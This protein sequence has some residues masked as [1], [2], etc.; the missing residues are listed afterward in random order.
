MHPDISVQVVT[1][2]IEALCKVHSI[3]KSD[4]LLAAPSNCRSLFALDRAIDWHCVIEFMEWADVNYSVDWKKVGAEF[5]ISSKMPRVKKMLQHCATMKF[6]YWLAARWIEQSCYQVLKTVKFETSSNNIIYYNLEIVEGFK[7]CKPLIQ[8]TAGL[9]ESLPIKLFSI[10][11]AAIEINYTKNGVN[12]IITTAEN[13]S[14]WTWLRLRFKAVFS[15]QSLFQELEIR[16]AEINEK[17]RLLLAKSDEFK[18]LIENSPDGVLIVQQNVIVYV[19][20][21]MLQYLKYSSCDE[22]IGQTIF[23]KI[24]PPELIEFAKTEMQK[25]NS[26]GSLVSPLMEFETLT[27]IPGERFACETTAVPINFNGVKSM[28]VTFRDLSD[29]K[30][31]QAHMMTTDRMVALGQLAAGVGHEI[32]NPL[33]Y[34][35]MNVQLLIEQLKENNLTAYDRPVLTIQKGLERIKTVVGDLKTVSRGTTDEAVTHVDMNSVMESVLSMA[36]NEIQH[37]AIL[38]YSPTLTEPIWIDETRLAQVLLNILINAAH[39]IPAG[40]AD[41]NIIEV[42]T[43]MNDAD[44]VVAE[45]KDSGCG[46]SEDVLKRIFEPF[47]TTKPMGS[48][49]GLGLAICQSIVNQFH[50]AITVESLEGMGTIFRVSFPPAKPEILENVPDIPSAAVSESLGQV[51]IIDDDEELLEVLQEVVS[52][53]HD[54]VGFTNPRAALDVLKNNQTFDCI[55]CDLMMPKMSGLQFHK[56]IAEH[57]PHYLN[58]IIFLTGGSFTAETDAF[59]KSPEIVYCEKPV[60]T[61]VLLGAIQKRIAAAKTDSSTLLK[62]AG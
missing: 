46:M 43:Y 54:C 53:K 48:G 17:N 6:A 19:N 18:S 40:H 28:A 8:F 21:R 3:S 12:F 16:Q 57:A 30:K 27:R 37:R 44:Y 15:I 33:C 4:M 52:I 32:N 42:K 11:P 9:L 61:R 62:K 55:I 38:K 41:L 25:L 20:P 50:G 47:Y 14:L 34:V 35:M 36:Q 1:S 51:M 29:R 22:L 10:A 39:S 31:L 13:L 59:L 24:V 7:H 58:R 49:T 56:T 26:E 5:N 23:E 60:D 2:I 45:I